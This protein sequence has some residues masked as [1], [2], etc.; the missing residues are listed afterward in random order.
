MSRSIDLAFEL[1]KHQ[2]VSPEDAGCMEVIA[3]YLKPCGFEAEWLNF[4]DT[5]NVLLRRG[6][7]T[8]LFV[9]LGHTDVVPSGP[10]DAW[11]SH[12]FRP[13]IREGYLYGRGAADMKSSIAAMVV[14][15]QEFLKEYPSPPGSIAL[16]LT[17][18]E[19]ALATNGI[20]KVVET[21][22]ARSEKIDWC[23]VGEPS[24]EIEFGDTVKVG[25]RGSLCGTLQIFGTQG[26]VAYPHLA[27]NPIHRVVPALT[28]L[29]QET[30]DEGNEYFPPTSFQISNI[31]AGTGAEN[32]IPGVVNISFNLRF[33]T[34]LD[35]N[36][37]KNRV[38][39]ILDQHNLNYDIDWRLS[40]NPFFTKPGKLTEAVVEA[41]QHVTNLKPKLSTGG[42]TSDGRFVAPT[43]AQIVELGPLN[44]TI[45]KVNECIEITDLEKLTLTYQK[46]LEVLLIK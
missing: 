25:R 35:E 24:S 28:T 23:L 19:E 46:I 38:H 11:N 8:P 27:E 40:G 18:D 6:R 34:E 5:K 39:R 13:E 16:M 32:V 37:I 42:G 20:V 12:P 31:N 14:A 1:I 30:W 3:S 43:G 21:L 36:T 44:T 9:F 33:S 2:S 4:D 29:V 41:T 10:I 22:Q 17:S 26:H 7:Q 15:C 45:H